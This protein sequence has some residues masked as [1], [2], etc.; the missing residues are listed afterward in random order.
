[1]VSG[2]T[3]GLVRDPGPAFIGINPVAVGV[4]RP[5]RIGDIGLEDVTI[6]I[7]LH[8]VALSAQLIV[9]LLEGGFLIAL[10]T[11]ITGGR[12]VLRANQ[13]RS[14][15]KGQSRQDGEKFK[16]CFHGGMYSGVKP[17]ERHPF[18]AHAGELLQ[19]IADFFSRSA[20]FAAGKGSATKD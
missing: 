13:A 9:K 4:G 7:G 3:P 20:C 18:D 12:S 17:N 15:G 1:M 10:I 11:L 16:G 2:P 5:V 8:P 19:R 14:E 6:I